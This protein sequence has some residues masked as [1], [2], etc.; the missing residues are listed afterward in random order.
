MLQDAKN[1][2][3]QAA[4]A[5]GEYQ[6]LTKT[7]LANGYCDAEENHDENLRSAYMAALM[8]RYWYKIYEW[9]KDSA[10]LQL[11]EDDFVDWLYESI[12][13]AMLYKL[14][15]YEYKPITS[16]T[17]KGQFE[18]WQLNE[19][20]NKIPN[21]YYWKKDS[22]AP[23]KI[24]NRCCFSTR[25]R[26]YQ[27]YNKHKRKSN[28]GNLSIDQM[29]DDKGDCALDYAGA[30]EESDKGNGVADL[31]NQFLK[32][33]HSIEA[34]VLDGVINHDVFKEKRKRKYITSVNEETGE[35]SKISFTTTSQKFD[36]RKLV[37]H[38]KESANRNFMN[39]FCTRYN[40]SKTQG[41]E[42]TAKLKSLS[43]QKLYNYIDKTFIQIKESPTLLNYLR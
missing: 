10:S 8:L 5:L 19:K 30:I 29:I 21:K 31:I 9:K 43:N 11:E 41:K 3:M 34:L 14:W 25:G 13:L 7:E 15:R 22:N 23:D 35:E 42:I 40:I 38:L 6:L 32:D 24:I 36:K 2:Y 4:S 27:Y 17:N 20:G 28:F 16:L 26:E 33:G 18:G 39:W 1:L 12:S 37:K